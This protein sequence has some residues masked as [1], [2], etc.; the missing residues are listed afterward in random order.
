MSTLKLNLW[1]C[2]LSYLEI[3]GNA[4]AYLL[5]AQVMKK[6]SDNNLRIVLGS[7]STVS[8]IYKHWGALYV[9]YGNIRLG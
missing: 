3:F 1:M 7:N 6:A 5:G 4:L 9:L 8:N 2:F